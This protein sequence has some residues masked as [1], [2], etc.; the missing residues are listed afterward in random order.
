MA[1]STSWI[2]VGLALLLGVLGCARIYHPISLAQAPAPT[3]TAHLAGS[4]VPQAWGDHSRYQARAQ[5]AH[6]Q[7]AVLTLE[8]PSSVDTEI[9]RLEVAEGTTLLDP[10]EAL[11]L[12]RQ[13]PLLYALYP[14]IPG[15]AALVSSG[16]GYP[17]S[18][19]AAFTVW[20]GVGVCL[21]LP[22]AIV[23]ARSN[24]RLGDFL[25]SRAWPSAPLRPGAVQRGLV[26]LRQPGPAVPLRLEVVYRQGAAEGRLALACAALPAP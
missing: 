18:D 5:R 2:P 25:R 10:E 24:H 1:S 8:N 11:G 4:L 15:L 13:H 6:L 16:Q 20:A 21:G 26:F 12:V 9:L 3:R 23:A 7:L 17:L 19:R 14:L 22:N